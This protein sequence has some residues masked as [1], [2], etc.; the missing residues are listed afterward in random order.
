METTVTAKGQIVIPSSIRR[1][2]G[3]TEG[4]RIHVEENGKEIILRP[5]TRDHVHSLRGK[6][7]GKGLMK[8]L[9]AEKKR[10]RESRENQI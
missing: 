9:M 3:I 2:L 10:E 8:A 1:R 4:T 5:I 7:R 6:F